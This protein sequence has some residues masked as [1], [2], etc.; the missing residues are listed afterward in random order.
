V[1]TQAG[2]TV[3]EIAQALADAINSNTNLQALGIT[4]TAH[5]SR[6][7]TNA[8]YESITSTDPGVGEIGHVTVQPT[9]VWWGS[10]GSATGYDLVGGDLNRLRETGGDYSDPQSTQGCLAG[11][12]AATYW[13]HTGQTVLPGEVL[14]YLMRVLPGGTYDTGTEAGSR[15]A[16][17]AA[18]GNDCP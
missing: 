4:A 7:V 16:G 10:V 9:R 15:D 12:Q 18:S 8:D 6:L 13:E 3:E 14:W 2:Q 5:G 1:N 17:I 11:N